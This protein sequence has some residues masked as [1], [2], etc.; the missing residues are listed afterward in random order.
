MVKIT[1]RDKK[2]GEDLKIAV[3][4]LRNLTSSFSTTSTSV[5]GEKQELEQSNQLV[6]SINT[7]LDK[8]IAITETQKK[9]EDSNY[10]NQVIMSISNIFSPK[11]DSSNESIHPMR[12]AELLDK[13]TLKLWICLWS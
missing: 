2:I 4:N 6:A 8:I 3:E 12:F 7:N 9:S 1:D 11:G 10:L 13:C 5:Q